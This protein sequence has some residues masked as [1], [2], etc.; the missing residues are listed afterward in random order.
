[1]ADIGGKARILCVLGTRPEALKLAPVI[2]ALRGTAGLRAI[3][4]LTGQH[5]ELV[6]DIL[7]LFG[8][9]PDFDL[10]LMMPRQ[11]L[12]DL[13][14]RLLRG[15]DAVIGRV[16]PQLVLVQ[17]DTTTAM[18]AGLA[19]LYR[20]KR[21]AHIE[22]GLRTGDLACP[23]PEEANRRII[24]ALAA[25]HF[26]PTETARRNLL[27][28]GVASASI[29]VT[30]NTIVDA[31][32]AIRA[33]PGGDARA[34][35]ARQL[36]K[37]ARSSRRRL[38]LVTSHR[39][40]SFGS[41]LAQ[42]CEALAE[43]A[44]RRDVAILFPVHPNPHVRAVVHRHL[45]GRSRI[46]LVDPLTYPAFVACMSRADILLTDS[47][48]VQEEAAVLGKP[49]LV[50]RRKSER[51]EGIRNGGA[52]LV[53]TDAGRIVAAAARLLDDEA[54]YGRMSRAE[55]CY[56]DGGASDRIVAILARAL[57]RAVA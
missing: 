13:T 47:G 15:L 28:E 55:S 8:I 35:T 17:G 3:V 9:T 44:R 31:L 25:I 27:V 4:C 48:G 39:R 36:P 18:A 45:A 57:M 22:A 30:G 24:R 6:D 43:L 34:G 41:G 5:R 38:L 11:S 1:M 19:A 42:L 40:E 51:V 10:D 37:I 2:T 33:R 32:N 12:V 7:P 16:D 26:A 56:G 54:A 53:G 52:M 21:L 20:Q 29:H 14:A 23:W 50:L 46:Q 49:V